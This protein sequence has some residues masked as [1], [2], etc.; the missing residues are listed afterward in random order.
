MQGFACRAAR[1]ASLP[2]SAPGSALIGVVLTAA[3]VALPGRPDRQGPGILHKQ[4]LAFRP[5]IG[6]RLRTRKRWLRSISLALWATLVSP[7]PGS[8]A[9]VRYREG[10]G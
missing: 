7:M 2:V 8:P 10:D 4:L 6:G 9:V 1:R 3:A 5:G